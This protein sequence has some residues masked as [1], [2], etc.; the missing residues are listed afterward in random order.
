MIKNSG[1]GESTT[2]VVGVDA[3]GGDA[4]GDELTMAAAVR[5]DD[6]GDGG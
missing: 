5:I 2:G 6:D 3:E 4:G 1:V